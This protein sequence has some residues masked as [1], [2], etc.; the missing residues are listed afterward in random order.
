ML[1]EEQ[2]IGIFSDL[3]RKTCRFL[4]GNMIKLRCKWKTYQKVRWKLNS[5]L[6]PL[7]YIFLV[8]LSEYRKHSAAPNGTVASGGLLM[9]LKRFA[10]LYR[11]SDMVPHIGWSVPEISLILADVT[12]RIVNTQGHLLQDLNQPWLKPHHLDEFARAINQKGAALD[13]CWGFIYGMIRPIC[14][15]G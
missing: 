14:R 8:K 4:I 6:L 9:L 7:G 11:L 15:S 13:N 3:T 2:V 1:D 10:Y 12:D 5:G